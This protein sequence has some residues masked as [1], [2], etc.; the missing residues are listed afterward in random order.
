MPWRDD[1][2]PYRVWVSEI[3]LQQTRVD[4]V[5]P[6]FRRFIDRFPT[7]DALAAA[8]LQDVLKRWEGLGYYSRARHLHRAAGVVV[9]DHAGVVPDTVDALR[10]LP[11]L[12]P[13]TA[14]AVASIAFGRSEPV[15]DGNVLRVFTRFY[16]IDTDI[17]KPRVR[18]DL[19]NRLRPVVETVPP[20]IFNQAIMELGALV[21]TPREP[22]CGGCP[23]AEECVARRERR[24][25]ELPVKSPARRTPH[26]EIAVGVVWRGDRILIARRRDD[27][28]LGG[29]WEFPG[30]KRG[31]DEPLA[32]TARREV[33]EE[34][35]LQVS[36]GDPYAA[37]RH[38]YSHFKIT[39]TAFRCRAPGRKA[40]RPITSAEVR[41]VGLDEL[42][43]FPF[44]RANLT[45]I[46]AIHEAHGRPG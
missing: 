23:L 36:V 37:V 13:Y 40:P 38:A 16:G 42:D 11:G 29:L 17:R 18:D 43:R 14:A 45:V 28:M 33:K 19:V 41:W 39:L 34:T 35:G 22:N 30:G 32:E 27:Q 24:V 44:P 26:H 4:T 46:R 3:M 8:D 2:T 12:G 31:Q 5:I 9:R 1:P 15:V 21:C 25:A 10:E 6:Y 7:V 20:E